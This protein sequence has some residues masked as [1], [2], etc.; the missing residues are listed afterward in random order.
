M[1]YGVRYSYTNLPDR[2]FACTCRNGKKYLRKEITADFLVL[3]LIDG[4]ENAMAFL[5]S[6]EIDDLANA[7]GIHEIVLKPFPEL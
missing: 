5:T 6:A 4:P 7:E 3:V 2:W 1:K